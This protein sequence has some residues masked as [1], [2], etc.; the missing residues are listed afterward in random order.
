[1]KGATI[2][3]FRKNANLSQKEMAKQLDVTQSYLSMIENNERV[4]SDDLSDRI[5]QLISRHSKM[6]MSLQDYI[7]ELSDEEKEHFFINVMKRNEY[8]PMMTSIN[9]W[10]KK[11]KIGGV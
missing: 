6:K 10:L 11:N 8:D 9:S 7:D 3:R 4:P 1:M 2:K 5:N